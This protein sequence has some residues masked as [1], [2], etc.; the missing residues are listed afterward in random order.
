MAG[1]EIR[2]S[3]TRRT[4]TETTL[5]TSTAPQTGDL[6]GNWQLRLAERPSKELTAGPCAYYS[7]SRNENETARSGAEQVEKVRRKITCAG[8]LGFRKGLMSRFGT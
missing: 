6:A 5:E 4:R 7:R 8:R 2:D 3:A 1:A